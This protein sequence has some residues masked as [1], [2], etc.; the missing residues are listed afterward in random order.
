MTTAQRLEHRPS[1][2]LDI[3]A[4]DGQGGLARR[5][6]VCI[7]YLGDLVDISTYLADAAE[8]PRQLGITWAW[9][10]HGTPM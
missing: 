8:Q 5:A 3:F 1:H 4:H 6:A 7:R 10:V 2:A 9:P